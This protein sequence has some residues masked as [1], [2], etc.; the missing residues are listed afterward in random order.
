MRETLC[1][2]AEGERA[3]AEREAE[4]TR[5]GLSARGETRAGQRS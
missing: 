2:E 3:S 5:E 1:L 4:G